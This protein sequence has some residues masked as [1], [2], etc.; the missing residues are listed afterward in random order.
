M[1]GGPMDNIVVD[2]QTLTFSLTEFGMGGELE[3][4]GD[5]FSGFISGSMGDADIYGVKR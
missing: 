3:F 1:G 5:E 2:G 4:E